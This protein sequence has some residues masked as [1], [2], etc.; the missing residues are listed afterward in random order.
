MVFSRDDDRA[1]ARPLVERAHHALIGDDLG[2]GRQRLVQRQPLLAMHDHHVID[3]GAG[4]RRLPPGDEGGHGR[5][6]LQ[7]VLIDVFEFVGVHVGSRMKPTPS[8]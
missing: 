8:A 6:G 5:H 1:L 3:V 7:V 4:Q 2:L